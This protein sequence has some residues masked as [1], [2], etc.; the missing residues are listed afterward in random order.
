MASNG[1]LTGTT[2]EVPAGG[3]GGG[4]VL[5]VSTGGGQGAGVVVSS[6]PATGEISTAQY[7]AGIS[8]ALTGLGLATYALRS[9]VIRNQAL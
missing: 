5:G 2:A 6:L 7:I 4:A 1:C 8:A 3:N 9:V